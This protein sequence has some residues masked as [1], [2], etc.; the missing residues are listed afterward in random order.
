MKIEV[1][2]NQYDE[3]QFLFKIREQIEKSISQ[4]LEESINKHV[5]KVIAN[6]FEA[7]AKKKVISVLETWTTNV[8]GEEMSLNKYIDYLLNAIPSSSIKEPYSR[9]DRKEPRIIGIIRRVIEDSVPR[10]IKSDLQPWVDD[11]KEKIIKFSVIK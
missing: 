10:E 9:F 5:A 6:L 11:L 7:E 2:L 1:T 8:E 3:E 4:K